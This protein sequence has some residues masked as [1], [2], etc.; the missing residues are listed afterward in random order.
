MINEN[1]NFDNWEKN[2]DAKELKDNVLNAVLNN[3][4]SDLDIS[5]D[6]KNKLTMSE[7]EV[8]Y[9]KEEGTGE[10]LLQKFFSYV[11]SID[12]DYWSQYNQIRSWDVKSYCN[13]EPVTGKD[14]EKNQTRRNERREAGEKLFKKFINEELTDSEKK[15][16]ESGWNDYFNNKVEVDP[17]TVPIKVEGLSKTFKGKEYK[18]KGVQTQFISKFIQKGVGCAAHQV[19]VGKT[20]SGIIATVSNMQMGRCKKPVVVVPTSVLQKWEYE[21]RQL[22]PNVPLNI[23]GTKQL[24]EK[25]NNEGKFEVADGSV[26]VMSYDAFERFGFSGEKF[27]QLTEKLKDQIQ[28]PDV[29]TST[30][31][32]KAALASV[33]VKSASATAV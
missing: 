10:T 8:A 24:N 14:A 25:L 13:K 9:T 4:Y 17:K 30:K 11:D 27:D 23:I 22:Y 7:E 32:D 12:S 29:D 1:W 21:F 2:P 18:I 3:S 6:M 31:A 28:N 16:L 20:M 26:T 15:Q 19:G 33:F 5:D